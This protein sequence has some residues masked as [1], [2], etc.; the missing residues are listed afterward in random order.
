VPQ[1]TPTGLFSRQPWEALEN[2]PGQIAGQLGKLGSYLGSPQA[3]QDYTSLLQGRLPMGGRSAEA[4]GPPE[5]A[6]LANQFG[7]PVPQGLP[8]RLAG[9]TPASPISGAPTP[10]VQA[11]DD[12]YKQLLSQYGGAPGISQLAGMTSLPTNFTP[13][14]AT[15]AA[16]LKDYYTAK[17]LQGQANKETISDA[18][19]LGLDSKQAENMKA[20]V[21]ANPMLAQREYA[22][23]FGMAAAGV[24]PVAGFGMPQQLA[25]ETPAAYQGEPAGQV[26][27]D[28]KP[29]INPMLGYGLNDSLVSAVSP[30]AD[31]SAK[32]G[33]NG[34][35]GTPGTADN[36]VLAGAANFTPAPP[37]ETQSKTD[38]FNNRV[39]A[40]AGLRA[41]L[42]PQYSSAFN[43]PLNFS[44][45]FNPGG[46]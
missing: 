15:Q 3:A 45:Y 1:F 10:I 18:L 21:N 41:K 20:W 9:A 33:L 14:G 43:T 22:K 28:P 39:E 36:S 44:Q 27:A 38:E 25:G 12:T 4:A 8:N 6:R 37:A 17:S 19:S 29:P 40:T 23:K 32:F 46:Q 34:N 30:Q 13:T 42:S 5:P 31:F 2:V 24:N 7:P 26:F 16:G 35:F 11:S